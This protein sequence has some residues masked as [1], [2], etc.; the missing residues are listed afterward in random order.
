M[1]NSTST[2][3][4]RSR[5]RLYAAL[6][7]LLAFAG[8]AGYVVQL[9]FQRLTAPWYL[10]IA[11]TVG[12]IFILISLRQQRTIWRWLALLFVCLIAGCEWSFLL[13]TRLPAYTGPLAIGKPF[14]VFETVRADGSPFTQD[15]LKAGQATAMVFFRG[16]W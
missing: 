12:V 3:P 16:R 8:I 10:P 13:L 5:G 7:L 1:T 6:G 9:R 15:D 2:N 4:R 14:P 11:A